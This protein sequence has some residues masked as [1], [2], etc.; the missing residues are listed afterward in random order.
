MANSAIEVPKCTN[1]LHV[2]EGG[3]PKDRDICR[4]GKMQATGN[5]G[6][7]VA[8]N[9]PTVYDLTKVALFVEAFNNNYNITQACQ[10]A[11]VSR[12]TFYDWRELHPEFAEAVD[13]AQNMPL[14]VAKELITKSITEGDVG[15]AKWLLDRRDPDFKPK[16]EVDNNLGLQETRDKIKDFLD[17]QRTDDVGEQHAGAPAT[18][19][20]EEVAGAPTDIS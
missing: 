14:R 5:K 2:F 16:A 19:P 12:T 1:E 7:M 13:E 4:C 15:T 17:E 18:E 6:A 10:Y 8:A 3:L 11:G 9:Q 20:R